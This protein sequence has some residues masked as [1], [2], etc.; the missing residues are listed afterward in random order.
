M[1]ISHDRVGFKYGVHQDYSRLL[2]SVRF[3]LPRPTLKFPTFEATFY[4]L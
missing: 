4:A 3:Y 1:Y 2:F